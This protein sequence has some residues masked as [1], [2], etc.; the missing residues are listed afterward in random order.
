MVGGGGRSALQ[1]GSDS[2]VTLSGVG[3]RR[4]SWSRSWGVAG[5]PRVGGGVGGR[6]GLWRGE[7]EGE[8]PVLHRG[9]GEVIG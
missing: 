4:R 3:S 2:E 5:T 1:A 6:M 7:G 8:G 9:K